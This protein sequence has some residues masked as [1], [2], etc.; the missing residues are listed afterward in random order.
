ME[1]EVSILYAIS[2]YKNLLLLIPAR[3]LFGKSNE[4]NN[5]FYDELSN[6]VYFGID[7]INNN[8]LN[9]IYSNTIN[10]KE[11]KEKYN[12]N[13]YL[14]KYFNEF[15]SNVYFYDYS[16]NIDE[17]KILAMEEFNKKYG[18]TVNYNLI[19]N[20]SNKFDIEPVEEEIEE[21]LD[22]DIKSISSTLKSKV[23]YQDK[24]I[25][26]LLLTLFN[27]SLIPEDK[28]NIIICGESGTGKTKTLMELSKYLP[29][30]VIY[31]KFKS[32]DLDDIENLELNLLCELYSKA[33]GNL[34]VA[35]NGIIIID[36]MD[37]NIEDFIYKL[38]EF[39][40]SIQTILNKES[41]SIKFENIDDIISF[42][43]SKLTIILS[44]KFETV[45]EEK[46]K[47][48][49]VP[50]E[51]FKEKS[52]IKLEEKY[53][54]SDFDDVYYTDNN[55]FEYFDTIISYNKLTKDNI[56]EILLKSEDSILK[57]Y[58]NALAQQDVY[59]SKIPKGVIEYICDKV[60]NS[61][62]NCKGL[63]LEIKNIL[64]GCLMDVMKSDEKNL[65]L[66]IKNNIM[67][68]PEKGYQLKK[69]K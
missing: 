48:I 43:T 30:P 1:K 49:I 35:E 21:K 32:I 13:D 53:L 39:A 33:R 18:I 60:Y 31:K 58:E 62:K 3:V 16:S 15:L 69:K 12:T 56:K 34:D 26:E 2:E 24:A 68:N 59:L 55:F 36:D 9:Y 14:N 64:K 6:Q 23:L 4:E 28:S 29:N 5:K 11:L 67:Y 47:S 65:E 41:M 42:D 50:V 38:E 8:N 25:D 51:Y 57:Q 46:E 17:I 7:Y 27:N 63:N 54:K 52:N 66:K 19:E 40:N 20:D 22:N 37:E 61:K 44:G 45:L 10:V